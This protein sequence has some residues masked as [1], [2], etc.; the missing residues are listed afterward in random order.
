M[1]GCGLKNAH[2]A[3]GFLYFLFLFVLSLAMN[4]P[5]L[6]GVNFTAALVYDVYLRGKRA[7]K[8]VLLFVLPLVLILPFV[9]G[10][11]N[12]YGVTVLFVLKN[13]N[14][15]TLEA[16]AY[17][18]LIA[19][20]FASVMLWLD[21][22]NE[23]VDSDKFIFLFGRFSP[24]TALVISMTLRF[25]PLL[26]D[27]Y[28]EIETARKGI[29]FSTSDKSFLRRMKNGV[30]TLSILITWVLESAI[31]TSYSM[32][33]RGYGL[34]GRT[35]Y[36]QYIFTNTDALEA[37]AEILLFVVS[38]LSAFGLTAVYNPV[39]EIDRPTAL[40]DVS[41]LFFLLLCLF[42]FAADIRERQILNLK[43]GSPWAKEYE[44]L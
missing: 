9:N 29:G 35:A 30:H 32:K 1:R 11:F 22:F 40:Q 12:H 31:D 43:K 10:L 6:T 23:I 2:P 14:N 38:C 25:I 28:R 27:G 16:L 4:H 15:F 33:A 36:N 42:P 39:I 37:A 5:I 44:Q 34:R 18:L 3:V 41:L 20:K 19:V 26:R 7:L 13:G 24:R 8:S 17:G 21:C